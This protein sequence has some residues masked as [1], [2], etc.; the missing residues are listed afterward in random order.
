[1]P[2]LAHGRNA[3]L[4]TTGR[5]F[6]DAMLQLADDPDEATRLGQAGFDQFTAELNATAVARRI[7]DFAQSNIDAGER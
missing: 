6:A 3:L 5:E 2:E 1:M 4:A 7:L